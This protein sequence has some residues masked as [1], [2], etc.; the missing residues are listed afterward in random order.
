MSELIRIPD[1]SKPAKV[2]IEKLADAI[3]GLARPWQI[4]RVARAEADA[5]L[6]RAEAEIETEGLRRRALERFVAEEAKRQENMESIASQAIPLLN[7]GADPSRM[8][9]DWIASFFD[10]C[11][12]V[13]D[14]QMQTLWAKL[15]AG[16][17]NSPGTCAKRT[18]SVLSTL[19][20]MDADQFSALANL[21]WEFPEGELRVIVRKQSSNDIVHLGAAEM[22]FHALQNLDAAG[23]IR[24]D[25]INGFATSVGDGPVTV[26]YGSRTLRVTPTPLLGP[27][28]LITVGNALLTRAGDDLLRVCDRQPREGVVESIVDWWRD[29]DVIA[30]SLVD[31]AS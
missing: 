4:R 7:P 5:Q 30:V 20:K 28:P 31:D 12:L 2:F 23:L 11:R 17:A 18:L 25:G 10:S 21:T 9:D 14:A 8:D 27:G 3:G 24:F 19:D 16:E 22:P 1:V 6:I 29:N 26:R 13:S 15:L